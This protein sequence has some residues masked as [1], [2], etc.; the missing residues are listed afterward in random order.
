ASCTKTELPTM[1]TIA[2][3]Y[4]RLILKI[5]LHDGDYVDAYYGP[6]SL[7]PKSDT[8]LLKTEY[9][10]TA[11]LTE[12]DQ[13][14]AQLAQIKP[15]PKQRM[16]VLRHTYLV[17]QLTAARTKIEMLNGK[18]YSFDEESRLLYD[19]VAPTYDSTHF[20]AILTELEQ[21]MPGHGN[22]TDRLEEFR[23][24]F[25]IPK[26]KLDAVFQAAIKEGRRRTQQY[27]PLPEKENFTVEY[28]NNKPWSGYNWYKGGAY[29][30]IQVNT[31][32][33]IFIDRAVDL[34]CHEGYPGHHVYNAL[35]EKTLVR[36]RGWIEFTVYPLFSPQSLIAEGSA[37][38]GIEMALPGAERMKFEKEVLFPLAGI[39]AKRVDEYYAVQA[40]VGKI[41]YAGNEAARGFI[42][43]TMTREQAIDWMVTY[44][45]YARERAEQRLRFIERYRSYVINYNYGLDLVRGYIEKNGGTSDKPETRWKL[46]EKLLSEPTMPSALQ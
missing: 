33:P 7:K 34:A 39:D 31:D 28:V 1:N 2:E 11:L 41:S 35:L 16:D 46:F 8:A 37:N 30:L 3:H 18:K 25:I 43:G 15:D 26:D 27:I 21:K 10:L 6:D 23:K 20:R 42:N 32:L 24:A 12:C 13:L 36:D 14:L 40:L 5:G 38:Y 29:S 17:K 4:V 9:A 22:L 45:M 19:A 44:G